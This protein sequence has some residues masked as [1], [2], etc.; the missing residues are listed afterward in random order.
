M[1]HEGRD[2][3]SVPCLIQGREKRCLRKCRSFYTFHEH[4][5]LLALHFGIKK[6]M[7]ITQNSMIFNTKTN[8][9]GTGYQQALNRF[10]F[11]RMD[12]NWKTG[13]VERFT[14]RNLVSANPFAYRFWRHH[15]RLSTVVSD[16]R[17][18]IFSYN[19]AVTIKSITVELYRRS[20]NVMAM[21]LSLNRV[22]V[23]YQ[24]MR[25]RTN[26]KE[27]RFPSPFGRI[28]KTNL[29]SDILKLWENID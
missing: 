19:H 28:E 10:I 8:I 3:I 29:P 9:F 26:Y 25:W 5:K 13:S 1:W 7:L 11:T 17:I 12:Q 21:Q 16:N 22:T 4:I 14:Q 27:A 15:M 24:I 18:H 20:L 23:A 2:A 6:C